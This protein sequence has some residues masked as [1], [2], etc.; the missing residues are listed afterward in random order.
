[1]SYYRAALAAADSGY[2]SGAKRLVQCSILMKEGASNAPRL[3][4]L[5]Q[6][7]NVVD[8]NTL[9]CLRELTNAGQF[10]KALKVQLPKTSKAHTIRGLLFAQL[11]RYSKAKEE[12]ALALAMDSGNSLAKQAILYCNKKRG[13]FLDEFLR[14]L[15]N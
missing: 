2:I 14:I 1:M 6:Q 5:L 10:K 8:S 15:G 11:K 13:G 7:Q 3:L 12:F 9:S 4:E